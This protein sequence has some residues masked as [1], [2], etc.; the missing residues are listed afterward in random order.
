MP[1]NSQLPLTMLQALKSINRKE[2]FRPGLLSLLTNANH[3][4]KRG[5]YRGISKRAPLCKGRLLDVG[6]GN[7]PYRNLFDVEE[8]TGIDIENPAHDHTHEPVDVIYDGRNIPFG[9]GTFDCIFSSEVFEH[10]FRPEEL[11]YE[12]NRVLKPGG[13]LLMT[14]PFAYIE[15]EKPYDFARYTSFGIKDLLERNGFKVE[16]LERTSTYLQAVTVLVA[17]YFHHALLPRTP[18]LRWPLLLLTVAP[19]NLIGGL[20]SF[21][22]PDNRDFYLNNLVVARKA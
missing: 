17:N 9:E 19:V 16:T 18:L 20:L 12:M 14:L 11:L 2:Q 13:V 15:H 22:L 3:F 4:I 5:I 21:L 10:V 6:C 7:K 8:Y 1:D